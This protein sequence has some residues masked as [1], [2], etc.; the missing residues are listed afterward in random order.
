MRLTLQNK[1]VNVHTRNTITTYILHDFPKF[2]LAELNT[3]CLSRNA[4]SSRAR[5]IASIHEQATEDPYIPEF[6]GNQ[7]GMVGTEI[8]DDATVTEATKI[9]LEM[10]D[11][12][13]EGTKK[14]QKLGIHK[15]DVNRPI[16]AWLR[17]SVIITSTDFFWQ[18]FFA[19]RDHPAAQPAFQKYAEEMRRLYSITEAKPLNI[20]AWYK[21]WED[22]DVIENTARAAAISYKNH[23]KTLEYDRRKE[24]HD[25]LVTSTPMHGSPLEHCA[26]AV[27]PGQM[28]G[29][30]SSRMQVFD[31]F[32]PKSTLL[33]CNP[34]L[35]QIQ[36]TKFEGFMQ[37]RAMVEQG[38]KLEDLVV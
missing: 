22:F 6:T 38:W 20:G 33:N 9:W 28:I 3:H 13:L 10:R 1:C 29:P 11:N 7:P 24:V 32:N 36:T 35:P 16:E 15:Q 23:A 27:R 26:M 19:L 8:A 30:K 4:E 34:N 21:P 25:G 37:Y 31:H 5:P 18:N 12:A 14:L 2:L 17:V